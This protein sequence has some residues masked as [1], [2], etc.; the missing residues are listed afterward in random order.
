MRLSTAAL[1]PQAELRGESPEVADRCLLAVGQA[2]RAVGRSAWTISL[3]PREVL[4]AR[5]ARRL[6]LATAVAGLLVVAGMVVAYAESARALARRSETVRDLAKQM[7]T[8]LAQRADAEQ[9]RAERERLQEQVDELKMVRLTRYTALELLNT[10]AFYAPKDIV[11]RDF[12]LGTDHSLEIQ[13]AAPSAAVV[14]D[15]Q[16]ALSAS[17]LVTDIRI[18]GVTTGGGR[19]PPGPRRNQQEDGSAVFT[20]RLRLWA[21]QE[22]PSTAAALA[23]RGGRT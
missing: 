1:F 13:G 3:L 7:K 12:K 8:A 16:D 14:A 4:V 20:M 21:Q 11:L 22:A 15:L 6:G 23:R 2:L 5:R 9:V 17:P 10:I 19:R 18:M